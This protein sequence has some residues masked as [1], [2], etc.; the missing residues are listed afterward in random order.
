M[1]RLEA[2][3]GTISD[4][5]VITSCDGQVL[6]CN[7]SYSQL[8]ERPPPD[9]LGESIDDQLPRDRDGAPLVNTEQMLAGGDLGGQFTKLLNRHKLRT[10]GIEWKPIRSEP[11]RPLIFCLRDVSA[12]L[13]YEK[14]RV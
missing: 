11:L 13:S 7:A 12:L 4:A 10:I 8:V 5:L 2:A 1:G 6:W 9:L 3:L 14:L